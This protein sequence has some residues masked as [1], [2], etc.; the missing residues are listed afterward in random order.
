MTPAAAHPYGSF[1]SRLSTSLDA[2]GAD[3]ETLAV[4]FVDLGL[5]DRADRTWGYALGDAV[6]ARFSLQLRSEVLR[7]R[8]FLGE[9]GRDELACV[10]ETVPSDG[11]ALLAAEKVLRMLDEP[12]LAGEHEL[13]ARPAIGIALFPGEAVDAAALLTRARA[14]CL[15]AR[16]RTERIALFAAPLIPPEQQGF[17]DQNRLRAALAR[18][19]LGTVFEPQLECRSS[20]AIGVEALLRLG[21]GEIVL[22]EAAVAV[23][24]DAGRASE[25]IE[26][27]LNGALR[28]VG[29]FRQSA[30]LDLRVAVRLPPHALHEPGLA[31]LVARALKTWNLRAGRLTLIFGDAGAIAADAKALAMLHSLES[32]GVRLSADTER[33]GASALGEFAALPFDELRLDAAL[34]FGVE[35]NAAKEQAARALIDLAHGLKREVVAA[36]VGDKAVADRL[37]ALGCDCMQGAFVSPPLDAVRFVE[38]FGN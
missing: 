20:R 24:A 38:K 13:Y 7:E 26:R 29:E 31:E 17:L 25:T 2:R 9:I 34:L 12:V 23:A 19:A 36:G 4:L 1:L 11:V 6:R 32:L 21:E 18:D 16:R 3:G 37:A 5:V 35:P 33:L 30:G 14:A 10:L 22:V 28:N 15:T 8:D 27:I